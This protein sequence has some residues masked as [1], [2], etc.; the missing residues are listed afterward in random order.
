[1]E[2]AL[3]N[4]Q[5]GKL[6]ASYL[7]KGMPGELLTMTALVYER[8]ENER[9]SDFAA[10]LLIILLP[11]SHPSELLCS[12]RPRYSAMSRRYGSSIIVT[13]LSPHAL[14]PTNT[15]EVPSRPPRAVRPVR[16]TKSLGEEGQ[17]KWTTVVTSGMSSPRAAT[18]V[19]TR[20]GTKFFWNSDRLC[21]RFASSI[22]P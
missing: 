15:T 10:Y 13:C 19:T 5:F 7:E 12:G 2:S 1:M 18:S 11:L 3:E 16:C 4:P 21:M 6:F 20:I 22:E 17:S 9:W 14:T 8:F